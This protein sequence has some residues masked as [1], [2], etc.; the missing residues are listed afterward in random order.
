[1]LF[2]IGKKMIKSIE[3]FLFN[4]KVIFLMRTHDGDLIMVIKFG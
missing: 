2:K 1:M 4:N 3:Q